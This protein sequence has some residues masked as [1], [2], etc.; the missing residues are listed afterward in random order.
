[1]VILNI[2]NFLNLDIMCTINVEI[3]PNVCCLMSY[4]AL[5]IYKSI[6]NFCLRFAYDA[7]KIWNDLIGYA[8]SAISLHSFRKNRGQVKGQAE[9]D[10]VTSTLIYRNWIKNLY[11]TMN[12]HIILGNINY[13]MKDIIVCSMPLFHQRTK[14]RSCPQ[15]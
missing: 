4:F 8:H 14:P 2:F 3:K 10:A 15:P 12:K 6:R 5:L 7:P 11:H 13:L 9:I 1:M